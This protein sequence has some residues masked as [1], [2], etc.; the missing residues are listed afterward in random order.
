M[1]R[2]CL[3][4]ERWTVAAVAPADLDD[5]SPELL[6]LWVDVTDAGGAVGFVPPA[7]R[8][9]HARELAAALARVRAGSA[10]LVVLRAEDGAV[11]GMG[12]LDASPAWIFQHWRTVKRL[13][14]HPSLRGQG[15]GLALLL[16]VHD[17]ARELGLEQLRL[18]LRDGLGLPAFYAKAG[19]QVIGRH[20]GAIRIGP[21]EDRD[22]LMML[23]Q[24]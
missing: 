5:L 17:H 1:A 3:V 23:V 12:F 8:D 6:D 11:R 14:V 18:T 21:G 19:Y 4:S 20:P 24:L 15:A 10:A 7:D 16:G 2:W 13:M 9:E 22:E